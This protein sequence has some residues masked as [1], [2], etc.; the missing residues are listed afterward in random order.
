MKPRINWHIGRIYIE[1]GYFSGMYD[2]GEDAI[3][4][5]ELFRYVHIAGESYI[6][7]FSLRIWRLVL[8]VSVDFKK[9]V[10]G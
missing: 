4:D 8:A 2:Y 9:E 1:A 10:E 7:I 6:S 3:A 5:F